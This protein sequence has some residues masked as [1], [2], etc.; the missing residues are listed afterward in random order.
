MS[1]LAKIVDDDKLLELSKR[2]EYLEI[3]NQKPPKQWIKKHPLATGVYYIPIDKIELLLTKIFQRWYVEIIREGQLLNSIYTTIRLHYIDPI[4]G[5]WLHQDGVGAV[6]I[7]VDKGSSASNLASIKHDAIMKGLP[8]SES[9]AIKDAAEKIGKIF[10]RD[11]NR[12][13][14]VAFEGSYKTREDKKAERLEK[15]NE[16]S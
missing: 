1:Q 8:A 10:G 6:P 5:E 2:D 9:F 16:S 7:Q 15:L 13:D 4:T 11:L 12:K 14:V 3:I